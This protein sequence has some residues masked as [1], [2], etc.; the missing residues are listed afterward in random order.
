MKNYKSL[1]KIEIFLI[2]HK[3][4]YTYFKFENAFQLNIKFSKNVYQPFK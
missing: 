1:K 2:Y 3:K 4:H